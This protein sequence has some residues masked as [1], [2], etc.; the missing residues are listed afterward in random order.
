MK[1]GAIIAN[2]IAADPRRL[3]LNRR[4]KST[5]RESNN[6]II[7]GLSTSTEPDCDEG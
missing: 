7:D 3:R 4:A 6:D 2:S 1:I 5:A